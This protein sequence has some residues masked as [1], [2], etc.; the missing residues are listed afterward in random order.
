MRERDGGRQRASGEGARGTGG[1]KSSCG[2]CDAVSCLPGK[3]P[4]P[5]LL[6]TFQISSFFF[7]RF[8][9]LPFFQAALTSF[10]SPG[11]VSIAVPSFQGWPDFG[12]VEFTARLRLPLRALAV[13]LGEKWR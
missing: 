12:R 11:L 5:L 10:T 6:S 8:P 9:P 2:R 1:R 13:N 3:K 4:R 7:S